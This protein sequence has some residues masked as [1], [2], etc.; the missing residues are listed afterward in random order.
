[1]LIGA[2]CY[3]AG[4]SRHA[5]AGQD[6]GAFGGVHAGQRPRTEPER[7]RRAGIRSSRKMAGRDGRRRDRRL[8][9]RTDCGRSLTSPYLLGVG[10]WVVFMAVANTMV[11][12]TQ[13]N[14]ILTDSDTF[15]QLVGQLRPVRLRGP[16][17]HPRHPA[18]RHH[19]PDPQGG[20]GLDPGRAAAGHPGG[21]RR[22]RRLAP[23]RRHADLQRGAPGDPL[24]HFAARPARRSS[25]S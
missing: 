13:A 9:P 7:Q 22:A 16:V 25:A 2:G 24:R 17:R 6:G 14:I 23:L 1:M 5:D 15:S 10:L 12:F 3:C 11:Y 19:P 8:V 18:L 21:L 4:D 20:R